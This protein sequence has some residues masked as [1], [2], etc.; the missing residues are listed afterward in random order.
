M[1]AALTL[2]VG[3]LTGIALF[4]YAVHDVDFSRLAVI[5]RE[6]DYRLFFIVALIAVL[7]LL[8]RAVKWRILLNP[9]NKVKLFDVFRMEGAGLALNNILPFRLGE[10]V[11]AT[12][13]AKVF[14]IPVVTVFATVVTE[15]AVDVLALIILLCIFGIFGNVN[16]EIFDYKFLLTFLFLLVCAG[17]TFLVYAEKISKMRCLSGVFVKFPKLA[18]MITQISMG[19]KAF[20]STKSALA[21]LAVGVIQWLVNSMGPFVLVY[22]FNLQ[23]KMDAAHCVVL[24]VAAAIACSVPAMPGFFGN[25]EAGVAKVMAVWGVSSETAFAFAFVSHIIGFIV[26]T[27]LG[28]FFIYQMGYSLSKVWR[29]RHKSACPAVCEE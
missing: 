9:T 29:I 16:G 23:D 26:I 28:I 24:T 25:Y 15:R 18:H 12:V 1:K 21:V 17:I 7:E 8:M 4:C 14:N 5:C 13:G 20:K 2:T 6:A 3:F 10:I 19:T 27:A 22:A 11:R